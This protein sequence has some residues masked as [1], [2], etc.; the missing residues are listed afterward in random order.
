METIQKLWELQQ[1]SILAMTKLA[2]KLEGERAL[3]A[4]AI[5]KDMRQ[6]EEVARNRMFVLQVWRKYNYKASNKLDR[7]KNGNFDD[8][9]LAKV[10]EDREKKVEKDKRDADCSRSLTPNKAKR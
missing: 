1:D 10:L 7:K 3:E 4:T 9:D 2:A 6:A 8:P 5:L